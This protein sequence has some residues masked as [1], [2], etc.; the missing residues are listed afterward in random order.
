MSSL[1]RR[2]L[3]YFDAQCAVDARSLALG[4]VGIGLLLLFDTW[5]RAEDLTA[6]YSDA[7]ALP[8]GAFQLLDWSFVWSL[9]TLAGS[10]GYEACLFAFTAVAAL[11]LT[12]GAW[13]RVATATSFLLALSVQGRNPLLHD[14]QDDLVRVVLF[15]CLWLP[16]GAVWS[17]DTWRRRGAEAPRPSPFAP[18]F[19]V[20]GLLAFGLFGQL[21]LLYESSVV[22]KLQSAWWLRG[23]G[24]VRALTLGRYE[25]AAGR[26]LAQFTLPLHWLSFGV[27]A[28]EAAL[29][30][31]LW[32][33]W[34]RPQLRV[35]AVAL[36]FGM[37]LGFWVFLRLSIFPPLCLATW[38]LLIPAWVWN[39]TPPA[40][41]PAT[42]AVFDPRPVVL[43]AVPLLFG[44]LYVVG[45]HRDQPILPDLGRRLVETVGLQQYWVVF[46][47]RHAQGVTDGYF[48]APGLLPSGQEVNLFAGDGPVSYEPPDLVSATFQ[49]RRWRHFYAK[50]IVEWLRGSAQW[51]QILNARQATAQWLCHAYAER[52]PGAPDLV[53]ASLFFVEHSVDHPEQGGHRRLIAQTACSN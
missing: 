4:R 32:I 43:A 53:R 13:T 10:S 44:L 14:G 41:A 31:L 15:F 34:R 36:A 17:V 21:T 39:R 49:N 46:A 45:T 23:E 47:P 40:E 3:A 19:R 27:M 52:H 7:G 6:H 42:P 33:P 16:L 18:P 35:V 30:L 1:W 5:S 38:A 8:R 24:I 25:T 20:S 2:S 9:H 37:H 29:P 50:L 28:L 11:A 51:R 26:W 22:G 48:V 12:V